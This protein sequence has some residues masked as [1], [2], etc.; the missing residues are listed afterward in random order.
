[1]GASKQETKR[2]DVVVQGGG[3]G[4]LTLARGLQQKGFEALV[5]EREAGPT[6]MGAGIWMA[7][8]AL[9]VFAELGII[10]PILRAS[11]PV[12]SLEL[13]DHTGEV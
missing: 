3:I 11:C 12:Q 7:P 2:V 9:K 6:R 10:E 4:G 8:N 13:L 5:V 1:M